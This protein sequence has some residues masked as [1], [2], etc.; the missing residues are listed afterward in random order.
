MIKHPN[1]DSER[2]WRIDTFDEEVDRGIL[3]TVLYKELIDKLRIEEAEYIK[4]VQERAKNLPPYD[5][6]NHISSCGCV[7]QNGRRTVW[8]GDHY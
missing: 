7:V 3:H 4:R 5:S 8:C 6:D 1:K 2:G